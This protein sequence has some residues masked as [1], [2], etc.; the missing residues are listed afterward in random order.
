MREYGYKVEI[1]CTN[2]LEGFVE[3]LAQAKDFSGLQEWLMRY[4]ESDQCGVEELEQLATVLGTC[5]SA[6]I[7]RHPHEFVS[8][9]IDCAFVIDLLTTATARLRRT[10]QQH[11]HTITTQTTSSYFGDA[12]PSNPSTPSGAESDDGLDDDNSV[13]HKIDRL[14]LRLRQRQLKKLRLE[15]A[16]KDLQLEDAALKERQ[17]I[18]IE[19]FTL[20]SAEQKVQFPESYLKQQIGSLTKIDVRESAS[21]A[22]PTTFQPEVENSR[23]GSASSIN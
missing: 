1:T 6:L 7:E 3:E 16:R 22:I 2:G 9:D 15:A 8:G 14:R 21:S 19:L 18:A 13:A 17:Q 10:S 23:P 11:K 4:V 12:S 20:L 5:M